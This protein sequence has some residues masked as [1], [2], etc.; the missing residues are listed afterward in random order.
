MRTRP[1]IVVQGQGRH[2]KYESPQ[3]V[4]FGSIASHTFYA[5]NSNNIKGGGDPQHVDVHCEWSGGSDADYEGCSV[6]DER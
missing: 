4:D 1:Q 2:M 3:V 5:G 6:V